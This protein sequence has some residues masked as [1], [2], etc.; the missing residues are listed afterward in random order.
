LK[1]YNIDKDYALYPRNGVDLGWYFHTGVVRFGVQGELQEK[2][3]FY[4]YIKITSIYDHL[5]A[6]TMRITHAEAQ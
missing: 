6:Y 3:V 4:P 2:A 1:G 5:T